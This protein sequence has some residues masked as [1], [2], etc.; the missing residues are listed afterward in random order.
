M[1]IPIFSLSNPI[2]VVNPVLFYPID[3]SKIVLLVR[4]A[5]KPTTLPTGKRAT[6]S[7]VDKMNNP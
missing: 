3:R 6:T 7:N 1:L 4:K 5:G 2:T